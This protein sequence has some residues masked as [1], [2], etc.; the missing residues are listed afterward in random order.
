MG[1]MDTKYLDVESLAALL[2]FPS[3]A[4]I[5]QSLANRVS[6]DYGTTTALPSGNTPPSNLPI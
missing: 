4:M 6:T 3:T 5:D 1:G 2:H